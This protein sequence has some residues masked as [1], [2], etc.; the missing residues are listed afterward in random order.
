MKEYSR[1]KDYVA[2]RSVDYTDDGV[3]VVCSVENERLAL[4][5]DWI[6]R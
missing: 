2:E 1:L 4:F 5:S 6:V 3:V